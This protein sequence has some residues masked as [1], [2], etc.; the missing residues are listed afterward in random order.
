MDR[1][2]N[3]KH[4]RALQAAILADQDCAF[5]V[6][7]NAD[8]SRI[9]VLVDGVIQIQKV[10]A[11]PKDKAIAEILR[12]KRWFGPDE[13]PSRSILAVEARNV[14]L[15]HGHWRA[16][17]RKAA[18]D[19]DTQVHDAAW[20]AYE[21]AKSDAARID[22]CLPRVAAMLDVLVDAGLCSTE[23]RDELRALCTNN[24][25][26]TADHVSRAL[27]GPWGDEQP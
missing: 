4:L 20:D 24:P 1:L 25:T 27:R 2:M 10:N 6:H 5:Y 17:A 22:A 16:I 11:Y 12:A 14:L 18:E 7:T 26:V 15:V 3:A 23:A 21:L 13:S 8:P 19:G 9:D